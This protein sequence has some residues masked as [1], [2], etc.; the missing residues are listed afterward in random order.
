MEAN[1][2][3]LYNM[4]VEQNERVK[5]LEERVEEL[6]NNCEPNEIEEEDVENLYE[7]AKAEVIHAQRA[8]TSFLQRR[9]NIGYSKAASLIDLL[10]ERKVIGTALGAM[11]R[12][13]FGES[14]EN[15][16]TE[17]R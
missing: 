5:K 8:S 7:E 1:I 13:V 3:S 12:E 9:L 15:T 4:I 6:E 11:P 2:S 16:K 10:E 14:K 17:Y